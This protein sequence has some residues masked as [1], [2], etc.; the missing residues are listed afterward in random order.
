MEKNTYKDP[1]KHLQMDWYGPLVKVK[2]QYILI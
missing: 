2:Q 1:D